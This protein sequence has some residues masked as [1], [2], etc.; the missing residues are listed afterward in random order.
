MS[1]VASSVDRVVCDGTTNELED[2]E[3]DMQSLALALALMVHLN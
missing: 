2:L 1:S 3:I